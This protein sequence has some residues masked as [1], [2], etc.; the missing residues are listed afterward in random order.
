VPG[1][2]GASG[3]DLHT[4]IMEGSNGGSRLVWEIQN[5]WAFVPVVA[6]FLVGQ[7]PLLTPAPIR[8]FFVGYVL[9]DCCFACAGTSSELCY[10]RF[11]PPLSPFPCR[12]VVLATR[13]SANCTHKRRTYPYTTHK[14]P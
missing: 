9:A 10:L 8:D 11:L 12:S 6:E 3:A 4:I 1:K 7:L 13:R 2:E 14:G 5:I